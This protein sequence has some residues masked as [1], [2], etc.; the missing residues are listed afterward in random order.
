M[1]FYL[2]REGSG[3]TSRKPR[4]LRP[5][6]IGPLIYHS[7]KCIAGIGDER[8]SHKIFNELHVVLMKVNTC[9][10][11]LATNAISPPLTNNT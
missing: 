2:H 8:P 3:R 10:L 1:S 7:L 6:A 9:A 5:N 11:G 4:R